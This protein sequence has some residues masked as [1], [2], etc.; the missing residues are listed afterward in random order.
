MNKAEAL[1]EGLKK[2]QADVKAG[3]IQNLSPLEK[4]K[5]NPKSLRLAINAKCYDCT[6]FQKREVKLCEMNDCPLW[7]VRPWK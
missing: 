1:K 5:Q 4:A 6:C 7:A 2:Y 3:L